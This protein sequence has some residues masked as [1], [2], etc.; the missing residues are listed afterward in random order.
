MWIN[1]AFSMGLLSEFLLFC[2]FRNSLFFHLFVQQIPFSNSNLKSSPSLTLYFP[3][4]IVL[5]ITLN[6][7]YIL[8]KYWWAL[9]SPLWSH[10]ADSRK[11]IIFCLPL[12]FHLMPH[13]VPKF[14]FSHVLFELHSSV[15]Y[16]QTN[17]IKSL[18]IPGSSPLSKFKRTEEHELVCWPLCV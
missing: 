14:T 18:F 10:F 1:S 5:S 3:L 9:G 2:L 11:L 17:K 8:L 7:S 6:E 4:L 15:A 16:S 12:T 13:S